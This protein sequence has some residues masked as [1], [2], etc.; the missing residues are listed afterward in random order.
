M[1]GQNKI[2]SIYTKTYLKY[3]IKIEVKIEVK[4]CYSMTFLVYL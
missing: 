4:I 2:S 1:C 3:N